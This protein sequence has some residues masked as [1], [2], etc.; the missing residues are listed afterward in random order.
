LPQTE[1]VA[2]SAIH[3]TPSY[4]GIAGAIQG[5]T[6]PGDGVANASSVIVA[7]E[8]AFTETRTSPTSGTS[9]TAPANGV[10]S[11]GGLLTLNECFNMAAAI[12]G[13]SSTIIVSE[14]SDYFFRT[15][16][17]GATATRLRADGSVASLSGSGPG[18]RWFVGA[19]SNLKLPTNT[20]IQGNTVYN[21][22]T[23]RAWNNPV[24]SCIGYN[25]KGI[26]LATIPPGLGANSNTG[27]IGHNRPL[28]SAHP[29]VVLAVFMDGHTQ[30]LTKTTHAAVVKRLATRDD[31]Q[32]IGADY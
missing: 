4:V 14:A 25:G 5:Q 22:T 10:L 7:N 8:A 13:T 30:S 20:T 26:V 16:T 15:Q 21:I 23:I 17:A 28:L 1:T 24:G 9:A 11:A 27:A 2:N 3:T 32:N 6:A 12:D 31:G 19:S 18:G 29:N